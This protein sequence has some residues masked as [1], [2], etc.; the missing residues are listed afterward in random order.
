MNTAE[1]ERRAEAAEM[2]RAIKSRGQE[3]GRFSTA[4]LAGRLG[5]SVRGVEALAQ[6]KYLVDTILLERLRQVH[7][8]I[9]RGV[10][11]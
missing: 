10:I 3:S 7:G 6:Q 2:I 9:G 8:V 5:V 4:W 1:T 11:E